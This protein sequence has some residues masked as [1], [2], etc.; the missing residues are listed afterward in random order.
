MKERRYRCGLCL[1]TGFVICWQTTWIK[2]FRETYDE[3]GFAVPDDWRERPEFA[4][5]KPKGGETCSTICT[6]ERA[7]AIRPGAKESGRVIFDEN[8]HAPHRYGD[9]VRLNAWLADHSD[10]YGEFDQFNQEGA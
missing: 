7:S 9:L 5:N 4:E 8:I 3:E 6:C 2:H 10:R 1:D